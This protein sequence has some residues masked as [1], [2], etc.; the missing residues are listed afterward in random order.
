M[1]G[2]PLPPPL[3]DP[4]PVVVPQ[5]SRVYVSIQDD[6]WDL[7]ALRVYGNSTQRGSE[8]LM[9]RLLEANYPLRDIA[10]FPGGVWV[11]VPDVGTTTEIPLVPWKSTTVLPTT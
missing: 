4:A 1:N 3:P 6:K 5:G 9:Y 2:T 8:H 11:I 10:I 7:I